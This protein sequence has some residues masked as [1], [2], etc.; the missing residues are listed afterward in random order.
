MNLNMIFLIID[1]RCRLSTL[2]VEA[3]GMPHYD[4]GRLECGRQRVEEDDEY[5]AA[6]PPGVIL[7]YSR[8]QEKEQ[9]NGRENDGEPKRAAVG[10][11]R[12]HCRPRCEKVFASAQQP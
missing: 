12:P 11:G 3:H 8:N 5:A 2:R 10:A 7:E 4:H 1:T 6:G 9:R